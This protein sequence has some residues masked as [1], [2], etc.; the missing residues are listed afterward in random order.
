MKP[1]GLHIHFEGRVTVTDP[2]GTQH[3]ECA[4]QDWTFSDE[5]SFLVQIAFGNEAD[6]RV[7]LAGNE[8]TPPQVVAETIASAIRASSSPSGTRRVPAAPE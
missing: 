2:D 8:R 6:P 7:T 4:R 3:T 5:S 1:G